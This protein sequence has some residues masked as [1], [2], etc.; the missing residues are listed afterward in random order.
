MRSPP[1]ATHPALGQQRTL[2]HH[3]GQSTVSKGHRSARIPAPGLMAAKQTQ[4]SHEAWLAVILTWALVHFRK[5]KIF[6]AQRHSHPP[7]ASCRHTASMCWLLGFPWQTG[8][9]H[10]CARMSWI[11]VQPCRHTLGRVHKPHT[12]SM[13]ASYVC[14]LTDGFPHP[15]HI[16]N[17]SD[18]W[19]RPKRAP[20]WGC[21]R[22][23]DSR[24]TF[25]LSAGVNLNFCLIEKQ[26]LKVLLKIVE[27]YKKVS[28]TDFSPV[29]SPEI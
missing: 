28:I 7:E 22:R 24:R 29:P 27:P 11:Y 23:F 18:W 1:S 9:I 16:C 15:A 4:W 10:T 20:L 5:A 2:A 6:T 19:G 21:G 8:H 3:E 12:S 26:Y 25:F 17:W 14:T 13:C